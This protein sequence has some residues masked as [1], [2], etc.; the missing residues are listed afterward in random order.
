M[1]CGSPSPPPA[2]K[3]CPVSTIRRTS[4]PWPPTRRAGPSEPGRCRSSRSISTSP[5]EGLASVLPQRG[6]RLEFLDYPG[7]WLLDL[8]LLGQDFAEWSRATLRRL[9]TP[10]AA[11]LSR[12]F[13]AF[14]RGLAAS[15]PAEETLAA[16]G[17]KLYRAALV[18]LRDEAGLSFLQ[19]GRFLMP[20]PGPEPPFTAFFPLSGRG[21]LAGLL[22]ARFDAYRQAVTRDLVSPLFGQVDRL[23]V[24]ADVTVRPACRGGGF[25]RCGSRSVR[26]CRGPALAR[27][28]DRRDTAVARPAASLL[29]DALRHSAG[30]VRGH[31]VGSR[32]GAAARQSR[33]SVRALTRL[34]GEAETAATASFAIA[35]VRCTEDFVWTLDGRNVSAVRGRVLGGDR[36]TR[37]YP[38]EVPDR[39]PDPSFWAHPFLALPAFEPRHL[40]AGGRAG[41]PQIGLDALLAFLLEDVL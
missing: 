17:H 13:L 22:A 21:A 5:R 35:A 15:A 37:S 38:G 16:T 27:L 2:R 25:R 36:M 41:V 20:A 40:P 31:E 33:E 32:R 11:P 12:D 8:P 9:E 19:P 34:P 6:L 26:G 7:E 10:E 39:P 24:L 28:L 14:V 4:P 23:V 30:R 1:R 29:A 3:R 18:R